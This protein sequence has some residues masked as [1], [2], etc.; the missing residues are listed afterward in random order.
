MLLQRWADGNTVDGGLE[1]SAGTVVE[2]MRTGG[3]TA[4]NGDVARAPPISTDVRCAICWLVATPLFP[5]DFPP[6]LA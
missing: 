3:T 5:F 6:N 1:G 2:V 4:A